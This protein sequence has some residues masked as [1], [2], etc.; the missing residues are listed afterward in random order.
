MSNHKG[1]SNYRTVPI[2]SSG[3]GD[4]DPP[5]SLDDVIIVDFNVS[6]HRVLASD[7]VLTKIV[8]ADKDTIHHALCV[9]GITINAALAGEDVHFV[10]NGKILDL[11]G[12]SPGKVWL[13]NSGQLIQ[14]PPT[15]GFIICL[16]TV[17][18]DST[19]MIVNIGHSII[20]S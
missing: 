18:D 13:G 9:I 17:L 11:A 14:V 12:M 2:G 4:L 15:T 7:T 6:S 20:R 8:Y 1:G 3:Q 16:G 5:T 10:T 19:T